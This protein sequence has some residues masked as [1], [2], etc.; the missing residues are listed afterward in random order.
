MANHGVTINETATSLVTPVEATAGL[1][2]VVGTAPVNQSKEATAPVN[3]PILCYSLTEARAAFGYSEDWKSYTL[4]EF[5]NSHFQQFALKPVVFINVLNPDEHVTAVPAS[6]KTVVDR[7]VTLDEEGILLDK[8]VVKDSGGATTY[9]RDTDYTLAFN[10]DGYVVISLKSTVPS[11]TTKL[12]VAYSKLDPG[13]VDSSDI[14]GGV[15]P[16]GRVTGLE[17]IQEVFPRFGLV[18]GLIL[19]PGYSSDPVVA[20]VMTAKASNINGVFKALALTD[21]DTTEVKRYTDVPLWKNSNNYTSNMQVP[22]WPMVKLGEYKYHMSTQLAG[23]I[24]ATDAANG[25]IPSVSPSNK[26][27]KANGM[28]LADGTNVLLGLDQSNYLNNQGIVTGLN[29]IGGLKAWGNYTGTYPAVTDPK[30]C[31]IPIRRMFNWVGNTLVLTYWQ[32]VDDP[33]NKRLTQTVVDSI[34]LWLNGLTSSGNLLG[35][36]VEFRAE[37]NPTTS[38]MAGIVHFKIFLTPPGPAQEL[39]MD[40]EYD[41]SYLSVLAA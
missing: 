5:M 41:A 34:N 27:F 4:C 37:D 15:D 28:V 2:V 25:G 12:S 26:S 35:G 17:L 13:A 21:I 14:I 20:S 38:L 10:S 16:E 11:D 19:A 9:K 23:V 6:D 1:P 3:V 40:L 22:L 24:G 29:F 33:T 32:K 39:V 36:R 7:M 30:D 31:F 8:V 18:P